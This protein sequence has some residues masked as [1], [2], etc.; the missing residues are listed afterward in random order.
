VCFLKLVQFRGSKG[1][2]VGR[3]CNGIPF[4]LKVD[5]LEVMVALVPNCLS[6]MTESLIVI[7][8][9]SP[10]TGG[11]GQQRKNEGAETKY[12]GYYCRQ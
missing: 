4:L 5:L 12:K 6:L 8:S 7:Y 9:K 2:S 1:S 11:D 10:V 3:G